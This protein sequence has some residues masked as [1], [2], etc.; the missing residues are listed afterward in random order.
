L[1]RVSGQDRHLEEMADKALEVHPGK[2]KSTNL[3]LATC[4]LMIPRPFAIVAVGKSPFGPVL[5]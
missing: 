3:I 5:R 1:S 2:K 4:E